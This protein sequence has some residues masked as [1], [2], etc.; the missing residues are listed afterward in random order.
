MFIAEA[1]EKEGMDKKKI[2]SFETAEEAGLEVQKI[3]RKGDLI[4]I[5]ASHSIGLD[6]IVEEIRKQ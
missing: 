1:A 6:R 3:I 4:L 5:K 2:H